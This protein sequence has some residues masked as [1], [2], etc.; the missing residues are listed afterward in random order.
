M[1]EFDISDYIVIILAVAYM[2]ERFVYWRKDKKR[3]M[4]NSTISDFE[5]LL[6]DFNQIR[7]SVSTESTTT[8]TL[9]DRDAQ[10]NFIKRKQVI[11]DDRT[12]LAAFADTAN[13]VS[14]NDRAQNWIDTGG[15]DPEEQNEIY[16]FQF[17]LL[18]YYF[19]HYFM[20]L[21]DLFSRLET[22]EILNNQD[23]SLYISRIRGALSPAELIILYYYC[24]V[25]TD[26]GRM[27]KDYIIKYDFFD[28][29]PS[30][31]LDDRPDSQLS[32]YEIYPD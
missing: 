10:G 16:E 29:I 4:Y 20:F 27:L 32:F 31:F 2:I 7:V 18:E 26:L 3:Q 28:S 6:S 19:N 12:G 23:R 21:H 13:N 15:R 24:M 17:V 1:S 14:K 25:Q 11:R 5:R 30:Y 9:T 22:N 8:H